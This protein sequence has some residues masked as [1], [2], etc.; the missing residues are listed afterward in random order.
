M[1]PSRRNAHTSGRREPASD[2]SGRAGPSELVSTATTVVHKAA[3]TVAMLDS[4]SGGAA[5]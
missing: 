1:E 3:A 5:S 2:L 4:S